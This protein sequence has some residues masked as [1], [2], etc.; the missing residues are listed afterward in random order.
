MQLIQQI[1]WP[2]IIAACLGTSSA[3]LANM[4]SLAMI[5]KVNSRLPDSEKLSYLWWGTEVR[6]RFKQLYPG[7]KL[8]YALDACVVVVVIS[9]IGLIRF[10]VFG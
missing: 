8:V 1:T 9:F 4:I 3:V 7:D 6:K 10:W 5:G 2:V